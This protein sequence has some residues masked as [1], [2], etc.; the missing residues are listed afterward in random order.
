MSEIKQEAFEKCDI[1]EDL[2]IDTMKSWA[3]KKG[4]VIGCIAAVSFAFTADD[5]IDSYSSEI[6]WV[7]LFYSQKIE[8][9]PRITA[10]MRAN[11]NF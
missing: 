10:R 2:E 3:N 9:R 4:L 11:P 5:L 8:F 1:G 7:D 6:I